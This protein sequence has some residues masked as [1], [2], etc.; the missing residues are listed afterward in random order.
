M[1]STRSFQHGPIQGFTF[2]YH[3]FQE[4]KLTVNVYFVDG[5]LIDTGPRRMKK[6]VLDAVGQ[7]P[8]EKVM[9]T[10]HHEDHTG[11]LNTLQAYYEKPVL[12]SRKCMELMQD[13][14]RLSLIQK[15]LFLDR[16]PAQGLTDVGEVLETENYRFQVVPIP[17]HASDMIALHEPD[18]GWLFSADLYVLNRPRYMLPYEYVGEQIR[19]M[20]RAL[21]LDWDVLLCAHNPK[22]KDG[23]KH[24]RKKLD[25][26]QELTENVV[27]GYEKGYS[28]RAIMRNIPV[29]EYWGVR[30]LSGGLL[31]A[32]NMVASIIRD[33][34][35]GSRAG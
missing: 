10:H 16:P 24:L 25:L 34:T 18:Q 14:P 15:A 12:A 9:V 30:L 19:S 31:S 20:E 6:D 5:L 28:I 35:S 1:R 7:L 23:K 2:G 21:A 29:K 3:P 4:P 13:P 11:N 33:H 8:V 17:G 27:A 22:L 32:R 26:L